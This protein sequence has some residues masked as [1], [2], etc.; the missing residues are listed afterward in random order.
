MERNRPARIQPGQCA[1]DDLQF[2]WPPATR[3]NSASNMGDLVASLY[4]AF[5][6]F[7]KFTIPHCIDTASPRSKTLK[8]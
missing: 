7:W 5:S 3:V 4:S 2:G 1:S 8:A 6:F